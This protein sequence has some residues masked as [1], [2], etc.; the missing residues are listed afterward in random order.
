MYTLGQ[1]AG[2]IKQLAGTVAGVCYALGLKKYAAERRIKV[3]ST[4]LIEQSQAR[5]N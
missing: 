4:A 3:S 5:V 1:R 2:G